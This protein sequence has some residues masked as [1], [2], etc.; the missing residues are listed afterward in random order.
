MSESTERPANT[1]HRD[2]NEACPPGAA[3]APPLPAAQP[4]K[5]LKAPP[6]TRDLYQLTPAMLHELDLSGRLVSV[7]DRWLQVFGY[8]RAEVI[9]RPSYDYLT[10][11]SRRRAMANRVLM[12]EQGRLDDVHYQGVCK[13]TAVIDLMVSSV[14]ELDQLGQPLQVLSVAQDV[15]ASM[16]TSRA[17]DNERQRLAAIIDGT[18]AGTWE[19]HVQTGAYIVDERWAAISGRSIAQLQ[20][21]SIQTWFDL[22]EPE[23]LEQ[24]RQLMYQHLTGQTDH[25]AFECRIWHRDGHWVWVLDS[26]RVSSRD[27]NGLPLR[28]H[29]IMQDITQ[30]K[31]AKAAMV[32]HERSHAELNRFVYMASNALQEP[33]RALANE[34]EQCA[35]RSLVP[36][37]SQAAASGNSTAQQG[38]QQV[39]HRARR[40]QRLV[41][42][43]LAYARVGT[44]TQALTDVDLNQ[45]LEDVRHELQPLIR[46]EKASLNLTPLPTVRGDRAQLRLLFEH[47]VANSIKFRADAL[48]VVE[49]TASLDGQV[50]TL[51]VSDNGMGF[52]PQQAQ[53]IFQV[54]GRAQTDDKFAGSGIGLAIA[55]RIVERHGG[56][57]SATSQP[58]LG[59]VF[60][61]TLPAGAA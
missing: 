13:S 6:L 4:G 35:Q 2:S 42:D 41:A 26:G 57:I 51:T 22:T 38:L 54:F 27:A 20:P 37:G 24:S 31:L 48:P 58:G 28:M 40:L 9:G 3:D 11:E 25:Y 39:V 14:V 21:L 5:V 29:G 45:I 44:S 15:T 53:R 43:L 19:W 61:F 16:A 18:G 7:S 36:G 8:E 55:R 46:A 32:D 30:R 12:F 50:W 17:L 60:S 33:L 52:D 59:S 56:T 47:L 1:G 49:I 23:E 34:A 10:A